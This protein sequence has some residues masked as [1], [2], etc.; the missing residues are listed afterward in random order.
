MNEASRPLNVFCPWPSCHWPIWLDTVGNDVL[1]PIEGR[2]P[3][4]GGR[5]VITAWPGT[6]AS[7]LEVDV[8]A[9]AQ[10]VRH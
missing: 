6:R 1:A 9:I 5:L 10:G 8:R 2:C 7:Q 4:C 3:F